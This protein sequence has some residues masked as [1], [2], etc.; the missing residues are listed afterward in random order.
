LPI[1]KANKARCCTNPPASH[2]VELKPGRQNCL[3]HCDG[4]DMGMLWN[5]TAIQ[6]AWWLIVTSPAQSSTQSS[7]LDANPSPRRCS[8]T[9]SPTAL[10]PASTTS[11]PNRWCSAKPIALADVYKNLWRAARGSGKDSKSNR[12]R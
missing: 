10:T 6:S 3:W 5:Y 8:P 9:S 11:P 12:H 7:T 4:W 1:S 2:E